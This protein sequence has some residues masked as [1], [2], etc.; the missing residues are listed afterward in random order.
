MPRW[1]QKS[2]RM[3]RRA[4]ACI[5]IYVLALHG[6][7]LALA[8]TRLVGAED[9][10]GGITFELCH[11]DG[12]TSNS[13]SQTPDPADDSCCIIC[14]AGTSYVLVASDCAP[15]SHPIVFAAVGWPLMVSRLPTRTVDANTRPRGPP[16]TA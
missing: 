11:H 12:N 15:G 2:K 10:A 1:S 9:N 6:V 4:T 5:L 8:G 13:P 3:W 16:L 14:L 7:A